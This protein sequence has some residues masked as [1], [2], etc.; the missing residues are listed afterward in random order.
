MII[1]SSPTPPNC[2]KVSTPPYHMAYMRHAKFESVPLRGCVGE[3]WGRGVGTANFRGF[4]CVLHMRPTHPHDRTA[5]TLVH[6]HHVI[7]E[8]AMS[9]LVVIGG[10]GGT[11]TGEACLGNFGPNA[12]NHG[13]KCGLA[14]SPSH[15]H[16]RTDLNLVCTLKIIYRSALSSLMMVGVG[17]G[18]LTRQTCP[19]IPQPDSSAH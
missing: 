15:P 8:S 19:P 18:P 6:S 2:L 4:M 13:F 7:Y 11:L 5:S 16:H 1:Y 3:E 17:D 14:L 10:G 9:S 12:N